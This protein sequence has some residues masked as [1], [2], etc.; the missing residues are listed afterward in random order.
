MELFK[1][2]NTTLNHLTL[3]LNQNYNLKIKTITELKGGV[4]NINLLITTQNS[5]NVL[6]LYTNKTEKDISCIADILQ[7]LALK[8][9]PSPKPILNVSKNFYSNFEGKICILYE[10]I[11]G[12]II[13][14]ISHDLVNQIGQLHG[15]MHNILLKEKINTN[16]GYWDYDN[17]VRII[18]SEEDIL[19][20][21]NFPFISARLNFIN[22]E[23]ITLSFSD[24]L[25]KGFTHQ[26]IKPENIIINND[27]IVGV[28]DYDNGYYG[29]LLHDFS[30]TIIWFCFSNGELDFSLLK[31]LINAYENKREFL[32]IERK[33]FF[34]SIKF[35]LLR[36]AIIWPIYVPHNVSVASK[37][38]DYFI[39]LYKNFNY[40]RKTFEN[41]W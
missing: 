27:K 3:F 21:S 30:T 40:D 13:K 22:K 28:I 26:D 37:Y 34:Q 7:K 15:E 24:N 14:H 17:L 41:L 32:P 29:C 9:F 25:P 16:I 35:R 18:A 19:L 38:C 8:G 23:L 5:N 4:Q 6:R 31:T 36:E 10:Y 2:N 1:S 11:E 12:T 20:K 39:T 33:L